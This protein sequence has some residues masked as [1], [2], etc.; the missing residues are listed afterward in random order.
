[1]GAA[2]HVPPTQ[3]LPAGHMPHTQSSPHASLITP[4]AIPAAV[5]GAFYSEHPYA[6]MNNPTQVTNDDGSTSYKIPYTRPDGTT[7]TATYAQM[8]ELLSDN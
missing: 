2:A 1:M 7:G 4:H 6:K 3:A 8:G 5:Q